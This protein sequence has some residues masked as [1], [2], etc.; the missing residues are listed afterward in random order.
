MV[1]VDEPCPG[2]HAFGLFISVSCNAEPETEHVPI[3]PTVLFAADV[4][5]ARMLAPVPPPALA[6]KFVKPVIVEAVPDAA[7]V[8]PPEALLNVSDELE[9]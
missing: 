2:V 9:P 3:V 8:V 5:V 7:V 1:A 4:D 6:V